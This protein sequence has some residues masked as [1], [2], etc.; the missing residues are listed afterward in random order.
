M[1]EHFR[2]FH[3]RAE[4]LAECERRGQGAARAALFIDH[5]AGVTVLFPFLVRD[6]A[7]RSQQGYG[8]PLWVAGRPVYLWDFWTQWRAWLRQQGITEWSARLHP[9]LAEVQ[10]AVCPPTTD[11][12]PIIFFDGTAPFLVK[13]LRDA[14]LNAWTRAS[15]DPEIRMEYFPDDPEADRAFLDIHAATMNRVGAAA[16]WRIDRT[17]L[18]V[19]RRF[20]T[21]GVVVIYLGD[22][23][24]AASLLVCNGR[25]VY[26]LY[27]GDLRRKKGYSLS[28]P[29]VCA[30]G[31]TAKDAFET[32]IA[33]HLGGGVT[34]APDDSLLFFKRGFGGRE[35]MTR[36][37]TE[38][39]DR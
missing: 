9:F 38:R 33:Y 7:V 22:E 3:Y 21:A 35:V 24:A 37:V 13:G 19:L 27:A 23:P 28:V 29:L 6:G 12:K 18:A 30:S 16:G 25:C 36:V 11:E 17:H 2:D 10:A 1:P 32:A 39:L 20:T 15:S 31:I 34:A 8:G 4:W 26:Y 14:H 5:Y